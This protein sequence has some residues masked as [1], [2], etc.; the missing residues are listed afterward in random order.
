MFKEGLVDK[1]CAYVAPKLIGGRDAPGPLGGTGVEKLIDAAM[2][3]TLDMTR[4]GDDLLIT[5]DVHRD[6]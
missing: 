5:A 6:S 3:N 4:L 2:L 1:V